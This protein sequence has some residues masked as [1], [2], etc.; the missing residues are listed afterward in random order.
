[1]EGWECLLQPQ[2]A[3]PN[4]YVG[5]TLIVQGAPQGPAGTFRLNEENKPVITFNPGLVNDPQGM[6]A[7][8]S[9]ELA[10]LLLSTASEPPPGGL[11][12]LEVATDLAAVFLGFGI[13][14]SNT[15]FRFS[16]FGGVGTTGWRV[17]RQGYLTGDELLHALALFVRVFGRDAKE[18][19]EFIKSS[20]IRLYRRALRSLDSTDAIKELKAVQYRIERPTPPSPRQIT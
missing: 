18:P 4:A 13:F 10:H 1:M 14:L 6:V 9:H 3:D 5:R 7:T 12:N 17:R 16:Q 19:E 20:S 8:L 11:D 2:E 15:S